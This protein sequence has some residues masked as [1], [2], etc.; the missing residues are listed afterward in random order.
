MFDLQVLAF[1]SDITRITSLMFSGE[2]SG[3]SYAEAGVPDSHHS[4]SHHDNQA[5]KLTKVAKIDTYH[6]QQ[7]AYFMGKLKDT[8]DGEG[9]LLDNCMMLYGAGISNGNVH[10][11]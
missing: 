5:E 8:P 2:R 4:V 9:N 7:L 10:D 11:Q 6:V 1:Q 3:R